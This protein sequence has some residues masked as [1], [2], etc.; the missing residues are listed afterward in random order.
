[1]DELLELREDLCDCH[2]RTGFALCEIDGRSRLNI[3]F[4]TA[5]LRQFDLTSTD[6]S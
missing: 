5:D 2:Y 4:A 1:L 3:G 6:G